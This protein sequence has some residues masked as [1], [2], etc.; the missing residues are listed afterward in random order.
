MPD[1]ISLLPVCIWVPLLQSSVVLGCCVI[2]DGFLF[3][4]SHGPSF[5]I[6]APYTHC[7]Y[8]FTLLSSH[9]WFSHDPTCLCITCSDSFSRI[10]LFNTC[11]PCLVHITCFVL[12]PRLPSLMHDLLFSTHVVWTC[13]WFCCFIYMIYSWS[14]CL[15]IICSDS[16]VYVHV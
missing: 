4:C 10:C 11:L 8:C 15:C 1:S 14:Y 13:S 7:P 9:I 5:C 3:L 16:I 6:S 12:C 2:F